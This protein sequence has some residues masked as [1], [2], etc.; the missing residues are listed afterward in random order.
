MLS[1]QGRTVQRLIIGNEAPKIIKKLAPK[2]TLL[3][4]SP[5]TVSLL[6]T[7]SKHTVNEIALEEAV[8]PVSQAQTVISASNKGHPPRESSDGW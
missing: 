7:F 5:L 2:L 3:F 6:N 1:L 4:G 8:T